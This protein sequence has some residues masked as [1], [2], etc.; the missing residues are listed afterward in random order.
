M[1]ENSM[2]TKPEVRNTVELADR[3]IAHIGEHGFDP[4]WYGD[5]DRP[6][7]ACFIGTINAVQGARGD[8]LSSRYGEFTE[9]LLRELDLIAVEAMYEHDPEMAAECR[10]DLNL[11]PGALAE[12]YAFLLNSDERAIGALAEARHRILA[13]APKVMA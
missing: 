13:R 7:P 8:R 12:T 3:A 4:S 1:K 9:P 10:A 6:C 11:V 5:D 2:I